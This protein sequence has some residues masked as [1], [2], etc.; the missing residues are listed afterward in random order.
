[1]ILVTFFGLGLLTY[2]YNRQNQSLADEIARQQRSDVAAKSGLVTVDISGFAFDPQVIKIKTG[3]EVVWTNLD[4][5]GH[6]ITSEKREKSELSSNSL[7]DGD[8]YK[9]DFRK[10]GIY[11]YYC[12][13]HS[14][15]KAAVIVVD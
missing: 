7:A 15:M 11:R 10:P 13:P 3:S 14:Q 2:F 9:H 1:M 8:T 5:V 12:I 6:T 4:S